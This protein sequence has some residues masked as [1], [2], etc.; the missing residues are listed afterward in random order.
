MYINNCRVCTGDSRTTSAW[1][2]GVKVSNERISRLNRNR[3]LIHR[4]EAHLL[5]EVQQLLLFPMVC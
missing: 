5:L 3:M 1:V 2:R 4:Y